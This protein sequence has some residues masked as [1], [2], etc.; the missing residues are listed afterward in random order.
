MDPSWA[1]E[2]EVL[3]GYLISKVMGLALNQQCPLNIQEADVIKG[4]LIPA[5]AKL[6]L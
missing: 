6:R 3:K 4:Y 1:L 5:C 2:A